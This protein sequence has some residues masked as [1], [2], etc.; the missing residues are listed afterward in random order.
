MHVSRTLT[1]Y[2]N[3]VCGRV[4]VDLEESIVVCDVFLSL[5]VGVGAVGGR[6]AIAHDGGRRERAAG[7]VPYN[8]DLD[9]HVSQPPRQ[10]ASPLL[11]LL[12]P[13]PPSRLFLAAPCLAS[14]APRPA[15][16]LLP[17]CTTW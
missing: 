15:V 5:F 9:L 16:R 13:P 3:F 10:R 1:A 2:P 4:F 7:G 6:A 11:A 12:L 8:L 14:L 17:V